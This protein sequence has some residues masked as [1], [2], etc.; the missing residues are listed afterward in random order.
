ML[1]MSSLCLPSEFSANFVSSRDRLSTDAAI[2]CRRLCRSS[3]CVSDVEKDE[4]GVS[5]DCD[6]AFGGGAAGGGCCIRR[7]SSRAND[8]EVERT[9]L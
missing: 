6:W 5:A 3:Y 4:E 1:R 8:V 2:I 9:N 7:G